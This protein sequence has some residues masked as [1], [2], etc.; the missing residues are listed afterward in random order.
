MPQNPHGQPQSPFASYSPGGDQAKGTLT[1]TGFHGVFKDPDW[2]RKDMMKGA[3]DG[4]SEVVVASKDFHPDRSGGITI[5]CEVATQRERG[6]KV[7]VPICGWVDDNTGGS[8][9]EVMVA[10]LDQDP[11]DVDLDKLAATTLRIRSEMRKPIG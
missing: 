5:T 1:V 2:T 10:T 9:A 11:S 4:N 8:V 3:Q 7:T 6:V